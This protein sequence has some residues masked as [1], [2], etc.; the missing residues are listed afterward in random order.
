MRPQ[1]FNKH[2]DSCSILGPSTSPAPFLS[3]PL[4]QTSFFIVEFSLR[5]RA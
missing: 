4:V 5:E 1:T 2:R 3:P